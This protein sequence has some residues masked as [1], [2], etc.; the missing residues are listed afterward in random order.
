M[1][2]G[3]VTYDTVANCWIC[4]L[5]RK[6]VRTAIIPCADESMAL[7]VQESWEREGYVF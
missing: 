6:G 2:K 4:T 5:Y 7:A 3:V 1:Y